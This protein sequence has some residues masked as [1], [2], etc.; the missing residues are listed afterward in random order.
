MEYVTFN[1][2][3]KMPILG[4]GTWNLRGQECINTVAAAI[5]IG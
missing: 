1:N 3:M 2:H 5:D 4:L